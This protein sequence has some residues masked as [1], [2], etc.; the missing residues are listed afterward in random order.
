[1][2]GIVK[3]RPPRKY[4]YR[5]SRSRAQSWLLALIFFALSTLFYKFANRK[6]AA[7]QGVIGYLLE[8]LAIIAL[9]A[10]VWAYCWEPKDRD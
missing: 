8:G 3:Y 1:M 10:A 6:V 2:Y 9:A 4:V 5:R 7:G